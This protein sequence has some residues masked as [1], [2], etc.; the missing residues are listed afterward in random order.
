MIK[1]FCGGEDELNGEFERRLG[2]DKKRRAAECA[3]YRGRHT[4]RNATVIDRRYIGFG[5][6]AEFSDRVDGV[7]G[8]TSIQRL[9]FSREEHS[10][11]SH[12]RN[13]NC[14]QITPIDADMENKNSSSAF[15]CPFICGQRSFL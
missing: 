10:A 7:D 8:S 11:A 3:P 14:P 12:N 2:K 4:H 13:R 5:I 15:I 1:W 9:K 6:M